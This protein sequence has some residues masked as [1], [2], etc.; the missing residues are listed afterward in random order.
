MTASLK[1]LRKVDRLVN[2]KINPVKNLVLLLTV[3]SL[4][5]IMALKSTN[6]RA[7]TQ[8]GGAQDMAAAYKDNKCLMCHGPKAAKFFDATKPDDQLVETV[9]KGKRAEKPPNMPAYGEK[10]MTPEQ[11]HALVE[12]MESLK[13]QP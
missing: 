10:G 6:G 8:E 3:F 5:G 1:L 7:Q 13:K 9:M 4:F 2:M 12:Y 11:A